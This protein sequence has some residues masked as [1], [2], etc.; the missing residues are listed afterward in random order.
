MRNYLLKVDEESSGKPPTIYDSC[1]KMF[2]MYD[3]I[4]KTHEVC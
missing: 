4:S 1:D 3:G 2:D